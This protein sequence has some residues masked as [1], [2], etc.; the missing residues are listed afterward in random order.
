MTEPSF[1]VVIPTFNRAAVV[2]QTL[3]HLLA[4]DYSDDRYEILVVD[5]SSDGTPAMVERLAGESRTSGGPEIRL[6]VFDERLPA[7]KRNR[8]LDAARGD[9]VFFVND[10]VWF[11]PDALAE[12]ARTHAVHAE[13]VAVLGACRQ[14][15]QM[16]QTP[17]VEFYEPFAYGE[18]APY[19][20][21]PVPYRYF[22]SMNLSLPRRVMLDRNLRFHEDWAHIGHEDVELGWRWTR[23]GLGA[24]YNPRARGDHYHPHT[25]VSA[26]RLQESIGRGL[27][28]LEAL[29][30]DPDLL[31]RYGVFSWRN[32]PRAV[33]RGLAR[34][35]LFNGWT[36][37]PL[38]SWLDRRACNT[39]LTR[40]LYWK[41]LL[42]S[43]NRGYRREPRRAPAPLRTFPEV[44]PA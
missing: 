36:A 18:M 12:H 9:L 8:G 26:C 23:A 41:V 6:L 43:T 31:E 1:S 40:W 7:V 13:P 10:D 29:V 39:R 38:A 33:A 17:F 3:R 25:V 5:N 30:P 20:D 35:A 21:R 28:D 37:P 16:V 34:E 19:A 22:W 11:E 42:H 24:I 32:R 14:S 44:V 2:E 27:R 4:Q 15:P